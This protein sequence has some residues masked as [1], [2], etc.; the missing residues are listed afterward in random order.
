M[1]VVEGDPNVELG[2]GG[3]GARLP[4]ISSAYARYCVSILAARRD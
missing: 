1:Y 3:R 4:R 2:G